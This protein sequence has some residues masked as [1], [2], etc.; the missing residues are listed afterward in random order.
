MTM[1]DGEVFSHESYGMVGVY[2]ISGGG[3]ESL[4][5]SALADNP[6][7]ICLK[8]CRAR[9]EHSSGR[10]WYF[11]E[12]LPIVE[13]WLTPAQFAEM[14]SNPN[15]GDGVPC[16]IRY[17]EGAEMEMPPRVPTTAESIRRQFTKGTV[18]LQEAVRAGREKVT[19][20]L[21]GGRGVTKKL[22]KTVVEAYDEATR[23][24][25]DMGPHLV[26]SF[27]EVVWDTVAEAKLEVDA[28][29]THAVQRAGM[30]TLGAPKVL[31][32]E[33]GS[34]SDAEVPGE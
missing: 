1:R 12:G 15:V 9:R 16:T 11:R 18:G 32:L 34:V 5:G 27:Q 13:L 21:D 8:V 28:F 10:D 24:V 31:E 17:V 25:W 20:A 22:R 19:G 6:T 7:K 30:E 3:R 23:F 4:F 14:L 29:I 2:R 33:A 26:D